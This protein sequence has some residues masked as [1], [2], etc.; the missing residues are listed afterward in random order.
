MRFTRNLGRRGALLTS[1]LVMG[2]AVA[3][4]AIFILIQSQDSSVTVFFTS[5]YRQNVADNW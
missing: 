4:L 5:L 1:H 2:P 3:G